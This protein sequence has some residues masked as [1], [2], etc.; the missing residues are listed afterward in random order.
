ML[1]DV[2]ASL[3]TV[4]EHEITQVLTGRLA[5]RTR[6]VIAHRASTAA[7]ADAV[8]WLERGRVRAVAPHR[9]L[10]ADAAYRALF[11]S[12]TGSTGTVPEPAG[13]G[14]VA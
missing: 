13:R 14:E 3:D 9:V 11:E 4:T 7:R 10:W 2:V 5:D 6:L 1:D 8:V 12:D